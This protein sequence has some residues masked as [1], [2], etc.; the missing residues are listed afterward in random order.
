MPILVQRVYKPIFSDALGNATSVST[1]ALKNQRAV[2]YGIRLYE[3]DAERTFV[4]VYYYLPP[5][6]TGDEVIDLNSGKAMSVKYVS[7]D[8][9]ET[10]REAL[11]RHWSLLPEP[12]SDVLFRLV[13]ESEGI[14]VP[15][16]LKKMV[17]GL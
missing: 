14:L 12:P 7:L 15:E 1:Y 13:D 6:P 8:N 17:L 3:G 2:R 16:F 11:G 4:C 10:I 5:E 9:E